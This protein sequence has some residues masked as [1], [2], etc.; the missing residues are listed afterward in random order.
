[1]KCTNFFTTENELKM[2]ALD[3]LAMAV[4]AHGGAFSFTNEDGEIMDDAP[5]IVVQLDSGPA[6]IT[7]TSVINDGLGRVNSFVG[8][9]NWGNVFRIHDF[10]YEIPSA[11]QIQMVTEAIPDTDCV[12]DVTIKDE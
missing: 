4:K 6:D 8:E 10:L 1:M 2:K 5:I 7:I 3:E 11:V 9:D 12:D